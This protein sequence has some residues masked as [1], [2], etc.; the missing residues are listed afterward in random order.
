MESRVKHEHL[1]KIG[2]HLL[3]SHI[4]LEVSLRVERS[5]FHVLLPFLKH[6]IGN[7]LTL[8]ETT[9]CHDTVTG[10]ADFI[11]ALDG[12][13]HGVEQR[14]KH[15]FD[16]LGVGGTRR[17]DDL[18]FAVDF[19]LEERAF[20]ADLLDAACCKHA[21]VVHLVEFILDGGTAAVD[22]KNFHYLRLCANV[23]NRCRTGPE[24]C[25]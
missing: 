12:T 6:G 18:R 19:R 16:T 21:L 25:E 14:V 15:Q 2:K 20:Q 9:T 4:T 8:R 24:K 17:L 1:G 23:S 22:Y 5:K 10:S 3:H 11:E 13:V 7:H